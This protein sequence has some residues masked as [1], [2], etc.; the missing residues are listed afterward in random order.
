MAQQE[1]IARA[2][3]FIRRFKNSTLS[4][5][6]RGRER[7]LERLK[8]GW[9][10]SSGKSETLIAKP[11]QQKKMSIKIGTE[12]RSGELVLKLDHV[13]VGYML[14]SHP[15]TLFTSPDLEIQ[16]GQR[17]AL[18]GPN[19]S[20]KTTL[21]RTLVG[22]V[23]PIRGSVR[24]G[25]RVVLNYY[26]QSHEGLN[27]R[28][29]IIEELRRIMPQIKENEARSLL[30][31]FLFSGDDVF[32]LVGDLSGGERSRVALAQLTLLGGNLLVLDEP[33]NHLDIDAREVLEGVL[34]EYNGTIL[35]VSHDRYFIDAVAD[36]IW[37]VQNETVDVFRG[38]YTEYADLRDAKAK[39]AQKPKGAAAPPA[40]PRNEP[41]AAVAT[42]AAALPA[43]PVEQKPAARGDD[44]EQRRRQRKLAAIEAEIAGLEADLRKLEAEIAAAHGDVKKITTLGGQH[45]EIQQM[46]NT[47]YDEWAAA[48]G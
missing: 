6:A 45:A 33:T 12:I 17:V 9:Q 47:R 39:A 22:E 34:N 44:R 46:L 43:K 4:T 42:P 11:D 23:P 5:Q 7:R 10:G 48:A 29:M 38:T 30:A 36:T 37:M 1:E 13:T 32:K 21:L 15:K 26:A 16:R 18:M 41:K 3:E 25:H 27:P 28:N 35:F 14:G 24:L 20:G 2:E 31:R 8:E 40:A 19:G